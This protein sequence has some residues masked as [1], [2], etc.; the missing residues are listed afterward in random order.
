[1]GYSPYNIDSPGFIGG[2]GHSKLTVCEDD[3]ARLVHHA[4][5]NVCYKL[6]SLVQNVLSAYENQVPS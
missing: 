3:F 6:R 4:E 2:S 5:E 1:M